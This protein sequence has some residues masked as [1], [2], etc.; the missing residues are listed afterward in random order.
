MVVLATINNISS[1]LGS[2]LGDNNNENKELTPQEQTDV[3]ED[4]NQND[5]VDEEDPIDKEPVEEPAQTEEPD[6]T[7]TDETELR[8]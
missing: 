2:L 7:V 8:N 5:L 1:M 3:T 6:E 4:Q